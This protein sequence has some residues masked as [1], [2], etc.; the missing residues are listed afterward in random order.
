MVPWWLDAG[1]AMA[2][3]ERSDSEERE[4]GRSEDGDTARVGPVHNRVDSEAGFHESASPS[5]RTW[6]SW[7]SPLFCKLSQA[8]TRHTHARSA[9]LPIQ[10]WAPTIPSSTIS[11]YTPG[12]NNCYARIRN[13]ESSFSA[14]M[15]RTLECYVVFPLLFL[16]QGGA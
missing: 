11:H 1:P 14:E 6:T 10:A 4:I 9:R 8:R 13:K 15:L 5:H 12:F 2:A 16:F 7:A 3:I